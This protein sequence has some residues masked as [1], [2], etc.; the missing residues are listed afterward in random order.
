MTE[1]SRVHTDRKNMF[2]LAV[3][4]R[5]YVARHELTD[6]GVCIAMRGNSVAEETVHLLVNPNLRQR[7]FG[8]KHRLGT[9][10]DRM[11]QVEKEVAGRADVGVSNEVIACHHLS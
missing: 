1:K 2:R 3:E 10:A 6:R 5:P 8:M 4:R 7:R 9:A 11:R